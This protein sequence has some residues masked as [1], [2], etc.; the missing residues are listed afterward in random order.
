[1][2]EVVDEPHLD[3]A[4]L[5]SADRIRNLIADRAR[6]ANVVKRQLERGASGIDE[7]DDPTRDILRLLTAVGQLM[8][9]ESD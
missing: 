5:R 9:I 6:Q 2:I 3:A 1:V 8:Q 4:R 7:V